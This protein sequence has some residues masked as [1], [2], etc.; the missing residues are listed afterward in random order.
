M[1]RVP[2]RIAIVAAVALAL[3]GCSS[4]TRHRLS[5]AS[6]HGPA[7]HQCVTACDK[8]DRDDDYF[9]CIKA[10]P[11]VEVAEGKCQP[12]DTS[13]GFCVEKHEKS[14]GAQGAGGLIGLVAVIGSIVAAFD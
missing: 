11:G 3:S 4:T 7:G 2:G 12:A 5:Y 10:C 8:G 1:E 13:W 6:P 14:S 9:D